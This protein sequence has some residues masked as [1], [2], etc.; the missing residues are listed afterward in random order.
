M[1][2]STHHAVRGF[3]LFEVAISLGIVSFGVVSVLMLL[4]AGIKAQQLSR[5]QILASVRAMEMVDIFSSATDAS[6]MLDREGPHPWDT[7]T[8][9]RAYAPD[10]ETRVGTFRFG[11]FPLPPDISRRLDSD[12]DEIQRIVAD[13]GYL[14]YSQPSATSGFN[15]VGARANLPAPN[16]SQKIICAVTGY[17]QQNAIPSLSY[18]DWPYHA[19]YP[20]PPMH[21]LNRDTSTSKPTSPWTVFDTS[22]GDKFMLWEDTL[23]ADNGEMGLV[24]QAMVWS[25]NGTDLPLTSKWV[26]DPAVIGG[27]YRRSSGYWAYGDK[28]GWILD[29]DPSIN[30][31]PSTKPVATPIAEAY[32]NWTQRNADGGKA[33]YAVGQM[34]STNEVRID[35]QPDK[36]PNGAL[37]PIAINW[38]KTP[39]EPT[40]QRDLARESALAYFALAKWYAEKKKVSAKIMDGVVLNDDANLLSTTNLFQG[41]TTNNPAL[42]VN[43]A[44]LLAHAA[45]C[46]T[47]HF[48]PEGA[49]DESISLGSLNVSRNGTTIVGTTPA[50]MLN[51][52]TAKNY[53]EN[54][55][56]LGMR[57]AASHPYDWGSPRPL[58]RATMMDFP[59]LQYDPFDSTRITPNTTYFTGYTY[60]TRPESETQLSKTPEQWKILSAQPIHNIGRSFCYPSMNLQALWPSVTGSDPDRFTLARPFEAADRTRQLVFWA[61][62]WQSYEDFETAPSAPVDASR[63]PKRS[64]HGANLSGDAAKPD[65]LMRSAAFHDRHQFLARNP[66]KTLA[67]V[68]PTVGEQTGTELLIGG[69]DSMWADDK[70]PDLGINN[71]NHPNAPLVF[72]GQYGADRNFNGTRTD[73][74]TGNSDPL[75]RNDII[76]IYGKLDRG[77]VPKSVRMRATLIGRFNFYDPRLPLA[78]R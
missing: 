56:K 46:V 48:Q 12:G 53:T 55:V 24:F 7:A 35:I 33:S 9:Y 6:I 2:I 29:F 73:L 72:S 34:N 63:Y 25:S 51:L 17:A 11:L 70:R 27:K 76:K 20:S 42:A 4:P 30:K 3:T 68:V 61:V 74:D 1:H 59:L 10:L 71:A 50:F 78:I 13:G 40:T 58:N 21:L 8:S 52:Q 26:Q 57:F 36:L 22:S 23:D 66:E 16:E 44:R 65:I 67:F 47:R 28:G 54:A 41:T 38:T 32:K 37:N 49:V 45:M 75:R 39:N 43:A 31:L 18:K 14:Y 62:D 77:P 15:P 64:P 69:N 19:P 5:Y 60:G